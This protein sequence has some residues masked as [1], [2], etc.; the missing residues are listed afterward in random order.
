MWSSRKRSAN[1]NHLDN[2]D[3]QIKVRKHKSTMVDGKN[4][5]VEW[6][7]GL[8]DNQHV[9][10]IR[11]HHKRRRWCA[12]FNFVLSKAAAA[13]AVAGLENILLW[14]PH[15]VLVDSRSRGFAHSVTGLRSSTH[16]SNALLR[17]VVALKIFLALLCAVCDVRCWR[18]LDRPTVWLWLTLSVAI[19]DYNVGRASII[20]N[21]SLAM[22]KYIYNEGT[23]SLWH[24]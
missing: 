6:T 21:N 19:I 14:K 4:I 15:Q 10:P 8:W 5:V 11:N 18:L 24:P 13:A 7:T 20:A 22:D 3:I 9:H 2:F 23:Q 1:K 17:D 12:S 16:T